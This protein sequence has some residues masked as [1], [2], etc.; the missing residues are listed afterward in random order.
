LIHINFKPSIIIIIVVVMSTN[1]F[2][3]LHQLTATR[4]TSLDTQISELYKLVDALGD[5]I[6]DHVAKRDFLD[7]E[8]A[9]R[10]FVKSVSYAPEK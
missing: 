5:D 1:F 9:Q 7:F 10:T 8:I 4:L 3:D 6:T 2:R